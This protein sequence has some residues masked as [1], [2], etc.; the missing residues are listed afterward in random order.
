[1]NTP[2]PHPGAARIMAAKP[3]EA[4]RSL[5]YAELIGRAAIG[6]GAAARADAQRP[7]NHPGIT[8]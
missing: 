7:P 8:T 4:E 2:N 6:A 3:S 5:L 1:M